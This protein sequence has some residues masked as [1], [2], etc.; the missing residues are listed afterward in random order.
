MKLK[1]PFAAL[2]LLI[3]CASLLYGAGVPLLF[4]FAISAAGL[5]AGRYIKPR[6]YDP[7][8]RTAGIQR[9]I[10]ENHIEG[11]LFKNNE[12][13]LATTDASQYVIQ[14]K[15]VHIP[16]AGATAS[17][18]K[19]RSSLP[20]SV[21]QRTD[22][23]VTYPLDEFTTDPILIPH[24]DTIELSYD[25]RESVI[26]EYQSALRQVI[27]DN[28][29]INWGPATA[30]NIVRTSGAAVASHL[31]STTGN[32]KK[33]VTADL[34]AAQLLLNKQNVP[35]EDRYALLSADMYQQL[36]DDLGVTQYRDFSALFDGKNG[37]LGRL[38][39]F[40]I[41]MRS[42][43]V[44]YTNAGTPVI[45]PY[46]AAANADDNDAVL[47]WQKNALERAVGEI[48]MYDQEKAP[49]YYGDI[50]SFLLRMGGRKRRN[51]E[52]GIVAIIQTATA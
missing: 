9:E 45:N 48:V 11:N 5:L 15:V 22:T 21:T 29:L 10:W 14:G 24:A 30:G 18:T 12:F 8:V 42:G 32:R 28:L 25:K 17:V 34:K 35:M 16:Q 7:F 23:D 13:L 38:F 40:N 41:M 39:G 27:A 52:K 6:Y 43:V 31:A 50:Y 44:T 37:I 1:S 2:L 36:T 33:I 20:A 19:N 4:S 49:T 26:G 46:G 3:L 51:D 47:C